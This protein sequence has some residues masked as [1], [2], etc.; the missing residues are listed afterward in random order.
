ME[1]TSFLVKDWELEILRAVRA[2]DVVI[3]CLS[4]HSITKAGFI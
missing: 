1:K 3:V 2:A 4:R